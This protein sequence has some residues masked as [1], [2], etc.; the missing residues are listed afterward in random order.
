M[1]PDEPAEIAES[2]GTPLL[3]RTTPRP[4]RP[5][6]ASA[7]LVTRHA[8]HRSTASAS[9][10]SEAASPVAPAPAPLDEEDHIL[11]DADDA[12]FR[13]SV[14]AAHF[15][16]I[17]DSVRDAIDNGV[18]PTRIAQGS[19]GSYFARNR[20]GEVVGV[21]KPR[22]E[23]PYGQANPKLTK[24][25]HRNFCWFAFGRSCLIPNVGYLSEAGASYIDRRLGLGIVP[26]TEI[27]SLASPTFHYSKKDR[28]AAKKGWQPLPPKV[29]SFQVFLKDYSDASLFF[30]TGYT[31][32]SFFHHGQGHPMGWDTATQHEFRMQFEKLCVLDVLIR[33]TDRSLSNLLVRD[34]TRMDENEEIGASLVRPE[35]VGTKVASSAAVKE[36]RPRPG[37]S[38]HSLQDLPAIQKD[39]HSLLLSP[40]DPDHDR[41]S[42]ES[43][44]IG[45]HGETETSPPLRPI[46]RSTRSTPKVKLGAIDNGLSFPWKHPDRYRSYPPAWSF[47]PLSNTPFSKDTANLI[48]PFLTSNEWWSRTFAELEVLFRLDPDFDEAMFRRQKA[49]LRGQAFNIVE[50]LRRAQLDADGGTPAALARRQPVSVYEEE[51]EVDA[52]DDEPPIGA[53]AGEEPNPIKRRMRTIRRRFE[54]LTHNPCFTS[55]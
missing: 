3:R 21:F 35:N 37:A 30:S 6:V 2:D 53:D 20:V 55:C 50:I 48:L 45:S 11:A 39:S 23:E 34:E 17:V 22:D 32:A 54:A 13:P 27:V 14:T 38:E 1:E 25:L 49:V 9:G 31:R 43:T 52:L 12:P 10:A 4:R 29:G 47:L 36:S 33:N 15:L 24:W 28:W 19:S 44:E 5:R 18:F 16:A 41:F 7:P 8:R 46:P 51:V 42:S 40:T 26:R